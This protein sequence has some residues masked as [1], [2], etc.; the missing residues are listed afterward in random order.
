M[1]HVFSAALAGAAAIV[2]GLASADTPVPHQKDGLWESSMTMMG[3]PVTTQSCVSEESQAKMSVFSAQMRQ[4]NCSSSSISHNMDGS[5]SSTS[6]CTFGGK[7]RTTHAH[8]T[9]SFDSKIT[10]VLTT[11][12]S[13]KPDMTMTMAWMGPCKPGMKGGDVWMGNGMKM[14]VLDGTMSGMPTPH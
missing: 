5:W 13:N 3:H 12:G 4:K 14:N 1:K 6:T 2:A 7:A 8:I 9:G 11:E 10:M